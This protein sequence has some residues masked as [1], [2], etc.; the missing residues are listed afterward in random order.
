MPVSRFEDSFSELR[1]A[2]EKAK[3]LPTQHPVCG[4]Y[5]SAADSKPKTDTESI[6]TAN[7]SF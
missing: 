5:G 4:C 2:L 1:N 6:E 7:P 3:A